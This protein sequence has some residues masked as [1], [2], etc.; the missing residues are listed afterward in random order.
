MISGDV[1]AFR[2]AYPKIASNPATFAKDKTGA[3]KLQTAEAH[4]TTYL[5][6]KCNIDV[7][8]GL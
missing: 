5:K 3:A 7:S 2:D 8:G 4:I 1:R 6:D